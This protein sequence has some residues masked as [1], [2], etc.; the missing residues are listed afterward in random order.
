MSKLRK[1]ARIYLA[2][3]RA[4]D[5]SKIE[6]A[7]VLD[8][9]D[10]SSFNCAA[11]LWDVFQQRQARIVITDRRFGETLSG[12][13]LTRKI[14]TGFQLPY[15]FV[16]MLSSMNRL[17]EIEEGLA[18]GVDDYLVRPPNPFQLRSRILVGLRWL[19]YIDSLHAKDRT[20]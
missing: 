6:D 12:T 1:D 15:C 2:I 7:L 11:A 3:R 5:R 16:I 19:A 8:G 20:R 9:F 18:A 4:A 17:R 14:R 10:I 13:D